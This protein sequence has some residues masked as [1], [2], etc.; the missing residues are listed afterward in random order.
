M[1]Y[2]EMKYS[3]KINF[4]SQKKGFSNPSNFLG[5]QALY[6]LYVWDS[7]IHTFCTKA[8]SKNS[9]SFI[10]I[11]V[12]ILCMVHLYQIKFAWADTQQLRLL[13][14]RM[15]YTR[16]I[17]SCFLAAISLDFKGKMYCRTEIAAPMLTFKLICLMYLD[18]VL[19]IF[20]S[21]RHNVWKNFKNL[22]YYRKLKNSWKHNGSSL[23][24]C[25]TLCFD[26]KK[27]KF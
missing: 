14:I 10:V 11:F 9:Y 4:V 22:N 25:I 26:V 19:C 16:C 5:P 15:L 18:S 24:S 20:L 13:C 7:L 8:M 27:L 1:V 2:H 12:F 3:W 17:I 21:T 6:S 23:P